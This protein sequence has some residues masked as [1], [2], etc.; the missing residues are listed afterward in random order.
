VAEVDRP[1]VTP[2][3]TKNPGNPP[4]FIIEPPESWLTMLTDAARFAPMNGDTVKFPM[5]QGINP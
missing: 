3:P 2:T 4:G 1:I 5:P